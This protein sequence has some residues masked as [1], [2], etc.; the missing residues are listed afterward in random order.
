MTPGHDKKVSVVVTGLV[1]DAELFSRSLD[2]LTGLQ[3]IDEIILATWTSEA[4]QNAPIL[5]ELAHRFGLK[6][7]AVP[8]PPQ[9]SGNLLSQM[10][11][12]YV[13]VNRARNDYILKT[14]TDVFIEPAAL[15]H[16]LAKDLTVTLPA[17]LSAARPA[18]DQK[19]CVW[20]VEAT[21]PFYIHDLF[22]FAAKPDMSRLINMDM[23]YDFLYSMSKER[24]HIRRFIHPFIHEFP[25]LE[26]F[27]HVEHVLGATHEF[28]NE[29]RY[30]VLERMLR[31][32]LYVLVLA[33]Y[34]RLVSLY[35]S[36]DWG[37]GD[38]FSWKDVP[39]QVPFS[40][41][42]TIS[43]VLFSHR[44]FKALLPTGDEYFKAVSDAAI[45]DCPLSPAFLAAV[46]QLDELPDL[47]IAGMDHDFEAF[48]ARTMDYGQEALEILKTKYG[49]R[50]LTGE[51]ANSAIGD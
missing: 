36:N 41:G 35:F 33:L 5:S 8:E 21:S 10:V 46:K 7:A 50:G 17:N 11:A 22:F 23:R 37:D 40:P 47:R 2:S 51:A 24:V 19:V 34:Y 6:V 4:E 1:R 20:G 16:V 9:W 14:R 45:G 48:L 28:P 18:F 15:K 27:L 38:V 26:K 3:G 31:E 49:G 43:D 39:D 30:L 25:I 12:L 44:N 42:G 13:G 29:Y 32:E